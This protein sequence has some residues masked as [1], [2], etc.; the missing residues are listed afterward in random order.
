MKSYRFYLKA[1]TLSLFLLPHLLLAQSEELEVLVPS[2]ANIIKIDGLGDE[3]A[4]NKTTW[5][6]DFWMWRPTDTLKA[7]KQTRFKILRDDTHLYFL[8]EA[9]VDGPNFTTP[10]LKRDFES[11]GADYLTLLF[12]TFSD[13]TNAFSFSTNPLG[14]KADGLISGGNQ[15]FRTD[16]NIAWDTKWSVETQTDGEK[17]TAEFKIPLSAFFYDHNNTSWRFNI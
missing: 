5:T 8:V 11:F 9:L 17:Y 4:W 2:T 7:N 10:S 13:A 16:R 15:N 3:M 12:D 6:S 14:V 1:L